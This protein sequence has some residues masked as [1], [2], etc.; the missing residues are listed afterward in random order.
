M[1][2]LLVVVLVFVCIACPALL[3]A[4]SNLTL[5]QL[6]ANHLKAIGSPEALTAAKARQIDGSAHF[7]VLVG[8]GGKLDGQAALVSDGPKMKMGMLFTDPS[9]NGEVFTTDG[10]KVAAKSMKTGMRSLVGGFVYDHSQILREGL[11][12]GALSSAWA[13]LDVKG[14]KAKVTYDGIKK[15]DDRQLHQVTYRPKKN[16]GDADIKLYFDQDFHHVMSVYKVTIEQTLGLQ[17]TTSPGQPV[18]ASET[19]SAS[20][21]QTRYRLEETFS[22]FKENNGLTLPTKYALRLTYEPGN[23]PPQA[24]S[25]GQIGLTSDMAT[26]RPTTVIWKYDLS[27]DRFVNAAVPEKVFAIQ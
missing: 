21:N 16:A 7:E 27:Y 11:L 17:P 18:T 9:Y 3:G 13:L 12:G 1:R 20:Q 25:L 14:H 23:N 4:D 5:D 15:I 6:I 8:G 22:D 10:D 26:N 2:R 19:A 24:T